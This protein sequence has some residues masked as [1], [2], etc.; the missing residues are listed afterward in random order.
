MRPPGVTQLDPPADA[1]SLLGGLDL[2][3]LAS[4]DDLHAIAS[5][6]DWWHCD[7]GARLFAAGDE[8][9]G[10]YLVVR[11][12]LESYLDDAVLGEI[13]QGGTVGETALLGGVQRTASVRA[14]RDS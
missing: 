9:D 2:L 8:A 4:D 13:A 1:T 6:I 5:V 3:A 7:A 11:G 14:V 12:R 10:M